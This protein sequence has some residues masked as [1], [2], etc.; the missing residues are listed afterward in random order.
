[1]D[2]ILNE[3]IQ[4]ARK[5]LKSVKRTEKATRFVRIKELTK[6]NPGFLGLF[7]YLHFKKNIAFLVLKSLLDTLISNKRLLKDLPKQVVNYDNIEELEDDINILREFAI[8]NKEFVSRLNSKLKLKAR[9]DEELKT[10]FTYLDLDGKKNLFTN[11]ISKQSRYDDYKNFRIDL[12]NFLNDNTKDKEELI[13]KVNDTKGAYIIYN[14]DNVIISEVFTK[15]ASTKLGSKSW[16]ISGNGASY[17]EQYAGL[18]TG[19]KQYFLWN[20]NVASSNIDS[21]VGITIKKNGDSYTAH[22]KNDAFVNIEPYLIK[23]DIPNVLVPMDIKKDINKIIDAHGISSTTMQL[24]YENDLMEKFIDII[25]VNYKLVY[26]LLSKEEAEEFGGIKALIHSNNNGEND[27][28]IRVVFDFCN[29]AGNEEGGV[30]S[31]IKKNIDNSLL[32]QINALSFLDKITLINN[33]GSEFESEGLNFLFNTE[34]LEMSS[35]FPLSIEIETGW[36][37]RHSSDINFS[38]EMSSEEYTENILNI[39][40][41]EHWGLESLG[42]YY[43]GLLDNLDDE[44]YNYMNY[45]FS[46]KVNTLLKEYYILIKSMVSHDVLEKQIDELIDGDLEFNDVMSIIQNVDEQ[47]TT[48]Y[49]KSGYGYFE[50]FWEDALEKAQVLINEDSNEYDNTKVGEFENINDPKWIISEKD[51]ETTLRKTGTLNIRDWIDAHPSDLSEIDV[52]YDDYPHASNY[53]GQGD[54]TEANEKLEEVIGKIINGTYNDGDEY[55]I[56]EM[57]KLK[58]YSGYFNINYDAIQINTWRIKWFGYISKEENTVRGKLYVVPFKE[59]QFNGLATI[60][61]IHKPIGEYKTSSYGGNMN[62][63]DLDNLSDDYLNKLG[64]IKKEINVEELINDGVDPDQTSLNLKYEKLK[65]F[66]NFKQT[67]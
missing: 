19:N 1:M 2:Q 7:T 10:V 57:S 60:Y 65:T 46:D 24:L 3:N 5:I 38:F 16:C 52:H 11:F 37:S 44:E 9:E 39:D 34:I 14:Q 26:G 18:K 4:K 51:I 12:I 8:Y 33:Y 40:D 13:E 27:E 31:Y 30:E 66:S 61:E 23:Y 15:Y 29:N 48:Y 63:N 45:F 21:K 54:L 43:G 17:W 25:P 36:Y 49:V 32:I 56:E 50:R 22:L 64:I 62:Y 35:D 59:I 6:D 58:D 67:K 47:F 20:F 41:D 42:S 28:N 53:I 55:S